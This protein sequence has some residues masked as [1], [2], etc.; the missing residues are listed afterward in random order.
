ME[1]RV[2]LSRREVAEVPWPPSNISFGI[3]NSEKASSFN[4]EVPCGKTESRIEFRLYKY[5]TPSAKAADQNHN[6]NRQ[7]N[8]TTEMELTPVKSDRQTLLSPV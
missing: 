4:F 6:R 8:E 3:D 1:Q 5:T 7:S 2:H